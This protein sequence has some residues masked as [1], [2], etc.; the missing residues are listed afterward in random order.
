MDHV[1]SNLRLFCRGNS[2]RF[3]SSRYWTTAT[4]PW[5]FACL[6]RGPNAAK[7]AMPDTCSPRH[8]VARAWG[9]P[10]R[11]RVAISPLFR[12]VRDLV[13]SRRAG[14]TGVPGRNRTCDRRIR[15]PM[16]YP[17][18]LRGRGRPLNP[19][20]RG[21]GT[22]PP[23][24]PASRRIRAE[25]PHPRGLRVAVMRSSAATSASTSSRVL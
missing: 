14:H 11:A 21:E 17:T 22:A 9:S 13:A 10:T 2:L 12:G 6:P 25:R 24:L 20:Q 15:N 16:L 19:S 4:V 1:G 3:G 5:S 23:R 7:R 8:N 18:E